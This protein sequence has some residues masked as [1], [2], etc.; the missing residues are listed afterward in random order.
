MKLKDAVEV[1]RYARGIIKLTREQNNCSGEDLA[2]YL[3][4]TEDRLRVSPDVSIPAKVLDSLGRFALF[5]SRVSEATNHMVGVL[6]TQNDI[7]WEAK[8]EKRWKV[9]DRDQ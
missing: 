2:E 7:A 5:A 8:H 4:E 1:A 6:I 9:I 3:N